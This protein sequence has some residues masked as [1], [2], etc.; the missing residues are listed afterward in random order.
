MATVFS[1]QGNDLGQLQQHFARFNHSELCEADLSFAGNRPH[2]VRIDKSLAEPVSLMRVTSNTITNFRRTWSHIRTNNAGV[3]LVLF[4]RSGSFKI[5]RSQSSYVVSK[6]ECAIL[7]SSQP[8]F[9]QA[10]NNNVESSFEAVMMVVPAHIFVSHLAQAMSLDRAIDASSPVIN[11]LVDL[12]LDEGELLSKETAHPLVM[13]LLEAL[14]DAV[15]SGSLDCV[16]RRQRV[17]DKRLADIVAYISKHFTNPDLTYDE[18]ASQCG[19]SPRYLCHVLKINGMSFSSLVWNQRL[20]QARDWLIAQNLQDYSIQEIAFMA[21]FKSAAHFSRMF[22][23]RYGCSPKAFRTA[24]PA[25]AE[26]A[27]TAWSPP[28][29][30]V[31]AI[32]LQHAA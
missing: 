26:E 11:R 14:G 6:N 28:T 25:A 17:V 4:V 29:F 1:Y 2:Q 20:P 23:D 3:R 15:D 30:A 18:V 13:A 5:V 8:Y 31:D 9:A 27:E 19:I 24:P 32:P 21:G 7:D 16:H 12:L 10:I 22:K